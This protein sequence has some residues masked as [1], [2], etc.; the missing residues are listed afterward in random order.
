MATLYADTVQQNSYSEIL[1]YSQTMQHE[2]YSKIL[3]YSNTIQDTMINAYLHSLVCLDEAGTHR[4][5]H[6]GSCPHCS[7]SCVR[8]HHCSLNTHFY[9]K[10]TVE[11][12]AIKSG[13]INI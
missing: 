1:L 6:T 7:H 11:K 4:D 3:L 8:S 12:H 13:Q 10:Q 5:T 9:L 2:S